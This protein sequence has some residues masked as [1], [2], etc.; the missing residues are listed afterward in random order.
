MWYW[1]VN[2]IVALW[3]FSD[4]RKRKMELPG[5]WAAACFA[6]MILVVPFYLARRPL[7]SGEVREG[8]AVWSFCRTFAILW[9][10]LMF[11]V[12]VGGKIATSNAVQKANLDP[13][14]SSLAFV[15]GLG[16]ILIVGVWAIVLAG[17]LAMGFH[18]RNH[19]T[20][21][22]PTGPLKPEPKPRRG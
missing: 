20:E 21:V 1:I 4:A 18:N 15:T 5:A 14:G 16:F 10:A 7:K 8:G 2:L 12:G 9:T 11:V 17:T 6:L 13:S 3:I 22:G 19:I